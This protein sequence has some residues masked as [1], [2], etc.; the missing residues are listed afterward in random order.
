MAPVSGLLMP[1][2]VPP[3]PTGDSEAWPDIVGGRARAVA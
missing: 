1:M 2:A 3:A